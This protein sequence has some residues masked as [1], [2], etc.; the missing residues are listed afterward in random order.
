MST[1][2]C[3][4]S[5]NSKAN[6]IHIVQKYS[7]LPTFA[8]SSLAWVYSLWWDSDVV[9]H[10]VQSQQRRWIINKFIKEKWGRKLNDYDMIYWRRIYLRCLIRLKRWLSLKTG[11]DMLH[12]ELFLMNIPHANFFSKMPIQHKMISLAKLT[13]LFKKDHGHIPKRVARILG[14][15]NRRLNEQVARQSEWTYL[16]SQ[17]PVLYRIIIV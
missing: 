15:L 13:S 6:S 7:Q 12:H 2:N 10:L 3:K 9:W 16:K 17:I 4:E 11:N 5:L 8:L 1:G 14:R